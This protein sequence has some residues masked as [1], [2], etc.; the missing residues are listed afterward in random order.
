M[1][2]AY[3]RQYAGDVYTSLEQELLASVG[4]MIDD[5]QLAALRRAGI[6]EPEISVEEL[7]ALF[8]SR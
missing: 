4:F 5:G 1:V 2:G 3:L 7:E 6:P 8:E